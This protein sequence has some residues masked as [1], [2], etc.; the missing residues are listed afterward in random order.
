MQPKY[1]KIFEINLLGELSRM[2][3]QT[4]MKYLRD[5]AWQALG[6]L[7]AIFA[8]F[9][10][11]S[12]NIA[13]AELSVIHSKTISFNEYL[14]PENRVKLLIEGLPEKLENVNASYFVLKNFSQFPIK[15]SDYIS[16]VHVSKGESVKRLLL[17][18]SCSQKAAQSCGDG[19]NSSFVP[20]QWNKSNNEWVMAPELLNPNESL[21]VVLIWEQEPSV[22]ALSTP[23][24]NWD[25]RIINVGMKIYSSTSE[26]YEKK[27]KTGSDIAMSIIVILMGAGVYWFLILFSALFSFMYYMAMRSEWLVGSSI[28][29]TGKALIIATLSVSTTEILIDLFVNN[30]TV[31]GLHYFAWPM[32]ALHIVMLTIIFIKAVRQP[33]K[34]GQ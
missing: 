13:P 17:V 20:A 33:S 1:Y 4:V 28:Q 30:R 19:N 23:L 6:V 18:E 31:K 7:V 32:L 11:I 2:I 5:P 14:L 21:C 24:F 12:N 27:Q 29:V 16:P 3:G 22:K 9:F 8:M 15:P 25:S 10:S 26:F 34:S